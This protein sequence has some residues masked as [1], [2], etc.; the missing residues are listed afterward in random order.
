VISQR[1]HPLKLNRF[2]PLD[3]TPLKL[4][5]LTS[6]DMQ[7]LM[8]Q[9]QI[10]PEIVE[11][12]FKLNRNG[13]DWT[14]ADLP[15]IRQLTQRTIET[16]GHSGLRKD[17]TRMAITNVSSKEGRIMSNRPFE[18]I[19]ELAKCDD[20]RPVLARVLVKWAGEPFSVE[21]RIKTKEAESGAISIQFS[22]EQ[23]LPP[24]PAIF[25]VSV[26]DDTE[27]KLDFEQ[28]LQYCLQ[29]LFR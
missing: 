11:S 14:I 4:V 9:L 29:I 18:L 8:S 3:S 6:H 23:T 10:A 7:A 24:G 19:I 15:K 17:A 27:V 16:I 1:L 20:V 28:A 25:F 21:R 12:I 2:H 22:R 26:F 5:D 13:V